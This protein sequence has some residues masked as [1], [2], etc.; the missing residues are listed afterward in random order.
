MKKRLLFSLLVSAPLSSY[1]ALATDTPPSVESFFSR[2]DISAAIMSPQG[3]Y[4]ALLAKAPE[5]QGQVLVI[6]DTSDLKKFTVPAASKGDIIDDVHWVNENRIAFSYKNT[7]MRFEGNWDEYAAN[8]DGS[9]LTH[10]ISGS[11]LHNQ[12]N[13]GSNI[14]DKVL[15]ADYGY[16]GSLNDGSDDVIVEKY[17]F[18]NVDIYAHTTHLYRL[19]T[20]TRRLSELHEGKQPANV[21]HWMVDADGVPRIALSKAAGRCSASYLV[22]DTADWVEIENTDCYQSGKFTPEA[23]DG[24][25]RLFVTAPY[26]GHDALFSYDLKS[27]Q[28]SKEPILSIEGF[29][30]EGAPEVDRVAKKVLGIH[31]RGDARATAWLDPQFKEIQ[32]KVDSILKGTVNTVTC[33]TDCLNAPAVLV[34]A[35]SD[36]MPTQYYIYTRATGT[37]IGLGSEHS[38]IKTKQGMR[39]FYRYPARDG[40]PIPIYVTMP[41]GKAQGPMPTVVLVH[42]GPNV[43]GSSWE[44]DDEAQFLASRGYVVL[45]PEYRGSTGFG[46]DHFHAG[47]KQWGQSM[48]DD[49]A[50]AA[51]WSIQKG[52]TDPKRIA[53]MGASYGGY[54]TL[55]GLIKNPELFRCG[56]EWAGVTDIGL[57]FSVAE[58][59]ATQEVLNYDLKTLIGDPVADAA[60]FKAN[61]PLANASKLMQ[62]LLIAHGAVDHRVPIVHATEFRDAVTKNN[63]NVEWIVYN[64]EGHGWHLEKDN[65]DFWTRVE[66]FLDKNLK[67]VN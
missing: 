6:R 33:G 64:D 45:Q 63:K 56:V 32:A 8:R 12:E 20:V 13:T 2:P 3:H 60:M 28:L 9:N 4:V 36:Q 18:N 34:E 65:I 61:S 31:F 53:I 30:F 22:P 62:P 19:N 38:G 59:D 10:L 17:L 44:W 14:K 23:L 42:G 50:D 49:L 26:K 1:A 46:F 27:R 48:Q 21:Y 52:W 7:N 41:P 37:L 16:Y 29:D 25:S 67:A 5:G 11:W 54:A 43:R 58:S 39:D 55:M 66:S 35:T 57:R 51:K 47:W 40:R 15:T 24:S